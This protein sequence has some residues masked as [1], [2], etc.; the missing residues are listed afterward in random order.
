MYIRN[1][2]P[3]NVVSRSYLCKSLASTPFPQYSPLLPPPPHTFPFPINLKLT[4][5]K[6]QV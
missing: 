4:Y 2:N 5:M 6:E 3:P 1:K